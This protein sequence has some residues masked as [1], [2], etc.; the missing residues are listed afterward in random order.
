MAGGCQALIRWRAEN[1][2]TGVHAVPYDVEAEVGT[3][4]AF[5]L[6]RWVHRQRRALQAGEP[7][8]RR[9]VLLDAPEAG[10]V[11]EPGEEAWEAELVALRAY[12]RATGH[13]TPRQ[14]TIWAQDDDML[15]IGRHMANLR[16]KGAKNGLG[17]DPD[18]AAEHAA[19][20]TAINEDGD[21]PWPLDW[22]RHYRLLA[23]LVDADGVLPHIAPGIVFDR[24]DSRKWLQQQKQPTAWAR[25]L[26][27][28]QERLA[29]IGVQ[30]E[31]AP[32]P[33]P[34]AKL[35][36]EGA[37]QG[38]TG[39]PAGPDAARAV[40][41][42]GR[43]PPAV[44]RAHSEEITVDGE[45]QPVAVKLGAWIT[46]TKTRHYKL[47]QEHLDALQELGMTDCPARR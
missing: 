20:L 30:P 40:G 26:P 42:A 19:L 8:D 38:T 31:Q 24:D 7:E 47:T 23:D 37:E 34:A 14:D 21:W 9:R 36:G 11:W 10:M 25:L 22:Q 13:L 6:G 32:S 18:R 45:A 27:E 4:K 43:P 29:A 2:I 39:I 12:R 41:G 5:P 35:R 1:E 44:P 3:T 33:A 15:P 46:N 16:R 17:K 28:Q